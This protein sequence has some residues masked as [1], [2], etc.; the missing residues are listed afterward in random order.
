MSGES[1]PGPAVELR[2]IH[3]QYGTRPILDGID[4]SIAR[5]EVLVLVG[6]SGSGKSTLLKIVS[7]IETPDRGE[8]WLSGREST[9]LP[10]YRR[11]VHTVFQNYALF[12][13]L[14]V[15]ANVAFPLTVAGVSAAEQQTRVATA[16]GWVRMQNHAQRRIESLSGGER[17]RVALA[18]ALVNE[19]QCVL[20]DEPLSAL[21]PHLR[22]ATLDLLE[23]IQARLGVTYLYITHDRDEALRLGRRI[24]VLNHGR[25]EHLGPPE[26]I[27]RRPRTA[28]V[29]SFL[30]KINWLAGEVLDNGP[31]RAVSL[32]G[33]AI[34]LNG[35]PAIAGPCKVGVRPEDVSLGADGW[36]AARVVSRQF[37]GE[38]TLLRVARAGGT[39]VQVDQRGACEVAVGDE[40]RLAWSTEAMHVFAADAEAA[41]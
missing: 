13:H 12:P 6:P 9:S 21:D 25:M 37:A 15:A 19:P 14:N 17:Q 35:Q 27:Y 2:G 39:E 3:K 5:G 26:E 18:R 29:A 4:L 24:G 1:Q 34:P 7:G 10:P 30:G 40:V 36:L 20:L 23:E 28:F 22:S 16:L 11:P 41:P 32:G 38:S 33:R 31:A 8:V